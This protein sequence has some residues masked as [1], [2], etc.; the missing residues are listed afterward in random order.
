M[1]REASFPSFPEDEA[2]TRVGH[3][4]GRPTRT[5]EGALFS[6]LMTDVE[7]LPRFEASRPVSVAPL[8]EDT[9]VFEETRLP[10]DAPPIW[11]VMPP[12]PA[13]APIRQPALAQSPTSAASWVLPGL[14]AIAGAATAL[15][16]LDASAR[17]YAEN[18]VGVL[19]SLV[20]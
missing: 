6:R 8:D 20:M 2:P 9:N 19:L 18:T 17:A 12:R 3:L 7:A 10:T 5:W 1:M 15:L 13:A 14:F 4:D 16:C 11:E